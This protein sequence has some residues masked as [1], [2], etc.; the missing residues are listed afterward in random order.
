MAVIAQS[1]THKHTAA[2]PCCSPIEPDYLGKEIKRLLLQIL[3]QVCKPP[4]RP[5]RDK[6]DGCVCKRRLATTEAMTVL[7]E[8][9]ESS[10][11]GALHPRKAHAR[12]WST[13]S[14]RCLKDD[15]KEALS[16]RYPRRKNKPYTGPSPSEPGAKRGAW[17]E[18]K[19]HVFIQR[20]VKARFNP[21]VSI[22]SAKWKMR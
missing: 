6:R 2:E 14:H 7:G 18:V 1:N 13:H 4:H 15:A 11:Q 12:P 21:R 22:I 17:V 8:H 5:C 19:T 16:H 20:R 10:R 3:S 9:A